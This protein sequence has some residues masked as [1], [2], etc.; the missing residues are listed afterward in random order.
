MY[1]DKQNLFSEDQVVTATA[2]STNIID[3]GPEA[4]DGAGRK[5]VAVVTTDFD[6]LTS[7]SVTLQTDDNEAMSSATNRLVTEAIPLASL[8]AGYLV[9]IPIPAKM[10]RYARLN[11]TVVGTPN[12]AGALTAGIV[13]DTQTNG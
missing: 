10:E 9:E 4:G 5:V 6:T 2:V 7:L 8:V 13:L 11:Y 1:L 12:V 3:L